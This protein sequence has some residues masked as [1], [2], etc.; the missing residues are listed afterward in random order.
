MMPMMMLR[1]M[2]VVVVVAAELLAFHDVSLVFLDFLHWILRGFYKETGVHNIKKQNK[3]YVRNPFGSSFDSA[4]L[5][6]LLA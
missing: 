1:T 4:G 5:H 2:A 6:R 3:C